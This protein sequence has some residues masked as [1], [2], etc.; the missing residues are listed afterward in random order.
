MVTCLEITS[1]IRAD[2]MSAVTIIQDLCYLIKAWLLQV[3][4]LS[5]LPCCLSLTC[6]HLSGNMPL[7]I[8]SDN[9]SV[10]GSRL[11]RRSI[12]SLLSNPVKS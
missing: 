5:H 11:C 9:G 6:P 2:E 1:V 7:N 10:L 4:T 12:A 8:T 3:L